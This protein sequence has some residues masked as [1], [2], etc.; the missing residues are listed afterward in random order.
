MATIYQRGRTWWGRVTVNGR[1]HRGSLGTHHEAIARE[2]F[3]DW[4]LSVGSRSHEHAVRGSLGPMSST[5]SRPRGSIYA[6]GYGD[7][8]KIGWAVS[9][10]LERLA[11]LQIRCPEDLTL[12]GSCPGS[13]SEERALHRKFAQHRIRGEWFWMRDEVAEW[14]E[15]HRTAGLR[16]A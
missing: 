10:P 1:E 15:Q 14:V 11:A 16:A 3:R 4:A 13:I 9:S 12:F 6:I 7:K 8:V 2:R 5:P